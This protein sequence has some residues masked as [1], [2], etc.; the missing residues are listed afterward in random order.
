MAHRRDRGHGRARGRR[1]RPRLERAAEPVARQPE[2]PSPHTGPPGEDE[3]P[4]L[5]E[6]SVPGAPCEAHRGRSPIVDERVVW[7]PRDPQWTL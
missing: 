6:V 1:E 4:C 7:R 5:A 2:V 3:Q